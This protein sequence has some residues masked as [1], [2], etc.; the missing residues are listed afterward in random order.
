MQLQ[1]AGQ[2]HR[3]ETRYGPLYHADLYPAQENPE[4]L[5]NLVKQHG[6]L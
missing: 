4:K 2:W 3:S 5:V 1:T 6:R